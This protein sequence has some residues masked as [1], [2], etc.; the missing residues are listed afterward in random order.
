MIELELSYKQFCIFNETV[1]NPFNDWSEANV[2]QGFS[3][4]EGSISVMTINSDG[5]LKV[6]ISTDSSILDNARRIIEFE[7]QVK[8]ENISIATINSEMKI[9]I[10]KGLYKIRVQL[11]K[12]SE[13]SELCY[14]SFS[15]KEDDD[16]LPRYLR[17]D[18]EITK[19]SD[20]E[21]TSNPV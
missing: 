1:S 19:R 11:C 20:F 3:I 17:F 14:L 2:A 12:E 13:E 21:L 6:S 15:K 10:K 7:Y 4:S 8:D 16:K 18:E 9:H 5:I